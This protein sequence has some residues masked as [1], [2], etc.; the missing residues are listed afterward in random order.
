MNKVISNY[1]SKIDKQSEK[2]LKFIKKN[3]IKLIR[4][5]SLTAGMIVSSLVNHPETSNNIY[6]GIS[7]YSN[8]VP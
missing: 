5:E 4:A 1:N 2:L 3:N 6:G 8:M 7:I